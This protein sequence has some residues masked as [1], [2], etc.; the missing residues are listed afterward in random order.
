[1]RESF[2]FYRSFFEA[3]EVLNNEQRGKCYAALAAY[4]LNGVVPDDSDP[5][6]KDTKTGEKV[7]DPKTKPKPKQNRTTTKQ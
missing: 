3:L 7:D 2:V 6:V 5:V 4:A 1:M